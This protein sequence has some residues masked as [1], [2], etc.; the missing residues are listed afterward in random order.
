M[1]LRCRYGTLFRNDVK[2]VGG[3]RSIL[4]GATQREIIV[5]KSGRG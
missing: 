5:T 1:K 2:L 3:R 4:T